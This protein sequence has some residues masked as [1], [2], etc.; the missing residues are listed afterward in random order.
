MLYKEALEQFETL[1]GNLDE[2]ELE[3]TAQQALEEMVK[4]AGIKDTIS[5][6]A[7]TIASKVNGGVLKAGDKISNLGMDMVVNSKGD[8]SKKI[9]WKVTNTGMNMMFHPEKYSKGIAVA[10]PSVALAG[11]AAK[12]VKQH[13]DKKKEEH[14]ASEED[15]FS[16]KEALG[17][18]EEVTAGMS[19][20]EI[21]V[22]A[23][24][25]L[26]EMDKEAGIG[27]AIIGAAKSV[28]PKVIKGASKGVATLGQKALETG[29]SLVGSASPL[30]KSIGKGVGN[31]GAA[32]MANPEAVA[33]G[34]LGG[35][36]VGTGA[37]LAFKG[38]KNLFGHHDDEH[39]ALEEDNFS[40]KEALA[41]FEEVIAGMSEEELETLAADVFAEIEKQAG[42][43]NPEQKEPAGEKL[44]SEMLDKMYNSMEK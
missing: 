21:E 19:E 15:D 26:E 11:V 38:L 25:T 35:A 9:G 17:I 10:V 8:L 12:G 5:N 43:K 2:N 34:A 27:S 44:A 7:K 41:R 40:Y 14:T 33:K 20:E 22:F 39:T 29:S 31:A 37:G 36:A 6:G 16:C 32:M 28:L 23:Q 42:E 24:Q 3:A 4:E 13:I 30:L 1:A 18:F